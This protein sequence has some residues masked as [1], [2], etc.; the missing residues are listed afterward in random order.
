MHA[1][2][3]NYVRDTIT[4]Y[5]LKG[6]RVLEIGSFNVNGSV[7][8]LFETDDYLGVDMREGPGVDAVCNAHDI[9][10]H[11]PQVEFEVIVCTEMLEHDDRFWET[12]TVIGYMLE[13]GGLLILTARGNGFPL[14]GYPLDFYRFM[15]SAAT[16][17]LALAQCE[18]IDVAEDPQDPGIFV[19]GRKR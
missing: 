2:V 18:K 7:R 11:I 17:L 12:M 14:H 5:N 6:K 16:P 9:P 1:S 15:P 3:M 4:H 8:D 19:V 10:Y 13:R